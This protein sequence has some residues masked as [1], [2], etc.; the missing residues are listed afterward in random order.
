MV[1]TS[2]L[3]SALPLLL[4]VRRQMALPL[5]AIALLAIG[6]TILGRRWKSLATAL[7]FAPALLLLGSTPG[8]HSLGHV[9]CAVMVM[10]AGLFGA[11]AGFVAHRRGVRGVEW[12][13]TGFAASLAVSALMADVAC[14]DGTDPLHLVVM[15]VIPVLGL[16]GAAHFGMRRR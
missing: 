5:A 15:H 6:T 9:A 8:H 11:F 10:G 13:P 14:P 12:A 3:A 1:A 2:M 16:V 7:A 4:G